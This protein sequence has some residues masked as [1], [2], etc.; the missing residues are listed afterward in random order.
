VALP[1]NAEA[2]LFAPSGTEVAQSNTPLTLLAGPPRLYELGSV[3]TSGWD[4]EVYTITVDLLNPDTDTLLPDGSNYG[5]LSVGQAV[6]LSQAISPTLVPPGTLTV[7]TIITSEI[8]SAALPTDGNQLADMSNTLYDAPLTEADMAYFNTTAVGNPAEADPTGLPAT[9]LGAPQFV[10]TPE[11]IALLAET[12]PL[13]EEITLPFTPIYKAYTDTITTQSD[14]SPFTIHNFSPTFT[15]TEQT[16]PAWSYTGTWSNTN[17]AKASGGNYWRNNTA[18]DT[19][20]LTFDGT[21]VNLGFITNRWSGQAAIT[22]DGNDYGTLDLYRT[23]E[24]AT[25]F[26][27][28]GL[29]AGTHTLEIE[30]LG[31]A[32]P[33]AG[34]TRVQLD[35]ADYGDGT[36]LPDGDF[37]EDD[38]R[39]LTSNGWST[40]AYAGASA[41]NYIRATNGTAWFP[42]AGDSFTLHTLAN[43]NAGK[44]KLFVDGI[45]LDTIDMFAPVFSSSSISRTFSYEG[46]GSGPHILQIASYQNQVTIDKMTTPGTGPF[47]DPNPPVTG[48]TRFEADHPSIQYNGVPF[49]QTATTWVAHR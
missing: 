20:T 11:P 28:D 41:G 9:L 7:T 14:G 6:Q 8:A 38:P 17:L 12:R 48:V 4:E 27:F 13:T 25:S 15:R 23:E 3:D 22:I 16:D 35:Y 34:N 32:N 45:Y 36:L 26:L 37:E 2:R 40:V 24:S 47:I 46:L 43:S 42:F 1:A 44:A 21:W 19:A 5:Y 30:V 29:S 39:L 49:T 31:T 18:G 10:P 33:F